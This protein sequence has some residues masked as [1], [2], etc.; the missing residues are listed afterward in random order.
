MADRDALRQELLQTDGHYRQLHEQH[1]DLERLLEALNHKSLHDEADET[2]MK[3]IKVE[4]LR[5][6]DA[7]EQMVRSREE[8]HVTA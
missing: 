4:K 8:S 5:L 3:R 1:K 6:K 2:E 7:M